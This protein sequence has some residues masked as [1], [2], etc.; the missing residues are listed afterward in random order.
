MAPH[1]RSINGQ[2]LLIE[3][4]P[5][6]LRVRRTYDKAN[7]VTLANGDCMK[8]MRTMPNGCADL[9]VTSPPYNIGKEYETKLDLREYIDQQAEVIAE[10]V[11]L[12]S[13]RGSICWQVGRPCG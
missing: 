10:C 8:L 1:R 4:K 13:N 9:V 2:P 11:R 12:L 3:P 7:D 5:R 6:K